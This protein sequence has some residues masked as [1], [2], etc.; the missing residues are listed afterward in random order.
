MALPTSFKIILF[1]AGFCSASTEEELAVCKSKLVDQ[2]Y[3]SQACSTVSSYLWKD[4]QIKS[5]LKKMLHHLD[6]LDNDLPTGS[7]EKQIILTL[8]LEDIRTLREFVN[9]DKGSADDVETI[10][11]RSID[12]KKPWLE[13]PRVLPGLQPSADHLDAGFVIIFQSFILLCCILLPLKLNWRKSWIVVLVSALAV[14][15]TWIHLYYKACAR[16]QA[17]LAKHANAAIKG[18]LLEKQGWLAATKDFLGGLFNGVEDPCE[19]YYTAAM[20]DPAWEVGLLDAFVE[21]FSVCLVAPGKACGQSLAGFYTH[22]LQPLPV[23]WKMPIIVLATVL[24]VVML[25]LLCGYELN[26]PF[27]LSIRP[28]AKRKSN[29]LDENRAWVTIGKEEEQEN[30]MSLGYNPGGWQRPKQKQ[31]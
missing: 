7:V 8:S 10:V 13:L 23:I 27:L 28:A 2:S 9:T 14:L 1:F 26:V 21:T 19:A 20:V 17:T 31:Q 6:L 3:L 15:Q 12:V 25:L 30:P 29:T 11:M 24:L 5:A 18:C 16:K 4:N 22:L